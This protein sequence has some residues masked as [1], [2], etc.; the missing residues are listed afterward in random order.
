MFQRPKSG[1]RA[2]LVRVGLG[3]PVSDED[4]HEFE[5]LARSAG[6]DPL[7]FVTGS[8]RTPDPRYFIGSGKAQEVRERAHELDADVVLVDHSLS[9]SQERNLERLVERRVLDRAGLIL[10]IFA[11]RARSA[12]GKLE[13][14]LAQLEHLSTRLVRGWTHLERQ[15]G[16]IGLRGPGE[17]QLETDRR[18]I[19]KRIRT[20]TE[21]L[22]RLARHRDTGRA[23]RKQVPV[24][25]LA[26]VGYTNAGKS[27]LFRAL[28]GADAY[29]ADQLFATLD[30]T[31]RR[32]RLPHC[33]ELV[34]ADTVGFVRDLPHELVAAFRSTLL[35]ARDADLLLHVVD[36]SDPERTDRIAQ[37]NE[38]LEGIGAAGLRQLVVCNKIDRVGEAPRIERDEAGS[39][40]R[41]WLSAVRGD[42][43]ELL[44]GCLA[45]MFGARPE[46]FTVRLRASEGRLRAALHAAHV[47]VAESSGDQGEMELQVEMPR[48]RLRETCERAGVDFESAVS[49]CLAREGFVESRRLAA[50]LS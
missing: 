23:V 21:R 14:E 17:T 6:A 22:A 2:L 45:E 33:P 50:A 8:R 26:L 9:P 37:V 32:I 13:V 49:P 15:K 35:E 29:V 3:A 4:V 40:A 36:A 34:V 28:T 5:S 19:S 12:E 30:P 16:G 38:V 46:R 31:V 18:L 10:D 24:P 47:V 42:G 43:I 1:E 25:A 20:L 41:V 7:A 48:Q 27:T 44:R 11:Q 39:P